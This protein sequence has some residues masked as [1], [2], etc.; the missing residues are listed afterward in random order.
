MFEVS[1]MIKH[2][3]Q[4]RIPN[5]LPFA[6]PQWYSISKPHDVHYTVLEFVIN[7]RASM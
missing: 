2:I 6:D 5:N 1:K 7:K 3:T 4:N